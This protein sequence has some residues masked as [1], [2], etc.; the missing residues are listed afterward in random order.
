MCVRVDCNRMEKKKGGQGMVRIMKSVKEKIEELREQ[1]G[2]K[3]N[4]FA[5]ALGKTPGWYSNLKNRPKSEIKIPELLK[6]A[7]VLNVKP[8]DLLP[9]PKNI[10]IDKMS[11][12][13]LIKHITRQEIE[14][15]F[16]EYKMNE[17]KSE[18]NIVKS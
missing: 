7:E 12:L 2:I 8:Q 10:E 13:D 18:K 14:R 4:E 15:Y 9:V 17:Y 3:Q 11:L 16:K 5:R 1:K 6:A